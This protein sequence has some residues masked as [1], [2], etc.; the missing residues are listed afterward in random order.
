MV[1]GFT[2]ETP[3]GYQGFDDLERALLSYISLCLQLKELHAAMAAIETLIAFSNPE[4]DLIDAALGVRAKIGPKRV[5][6]GENNSLSVCMIARNEK[7]YLVG[8]EKQLSAG[9]FKCDQKIR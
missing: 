8:L 5:G 1:T 7:H 3:P 2:S 9:L 4:D 6:Q